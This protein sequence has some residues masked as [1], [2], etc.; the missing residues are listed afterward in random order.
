MSDRRLSAEMRQTR[1]DELKGQRFAFGSLS[2]REK[3]EANAL[4]DLDV[5]EGE[6]STMTQ[7]VGLA[8]TAVPD[9]E[10]DVR[11]PIGMM[12][13]VVATVTQ[14]RADLATAQAQVA[15]LWDALELIAQRKPPATNDQQFYD[16][17][18]VVL[19]SAEANNVYIAQI[20]AKARREA[21]EEAQENLK[22]ATDEAEIAGVMQRMVAQSKE[23]G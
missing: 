13:R 9:M 3:F 20:R 16:H 19:E 22:Y 4:H 8:T 11:D 12:H 17:M 7:A 15:A 1:K 14:L 2:E 18:K 5:L 10:I 23:A 6:I 21:L